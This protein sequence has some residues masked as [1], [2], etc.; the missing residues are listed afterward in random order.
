MTKRI[1]IS[2]IFSILCAGFEGASDGA[3]PEIGG[4]QVNSHEVHGSPHFD[5]HEHDGDSQHDDH[6]CH[7]SVHAAALLF[8]VE[9]SA[10][11]ERSVLRGRY[12]DH[13]SS[14]ADPPL[15]R[16]PIS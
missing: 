7:C 13:F 2:L 11:K 4:S 12:D 6:F 5:N 14:L 3:G 1:I 8:T 16:P 15:L 9:Y 10:T